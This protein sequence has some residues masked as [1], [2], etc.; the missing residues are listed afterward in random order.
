MRGARGTTGYRKRKA[1]ER[2]ETTLREYLE[3]LSPE[4]L[5]ALLI[6]DLEEQRQ[7]RE[8]GDSKLRPKPAMRTDRLS[9]PG[10]PA[11]PTDRSPT[12]VPQK[13]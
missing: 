8:I 3:S 11:V 7:R 10:R 5:T 9:R 4:K 2:A 13:T 1:N 12:S 6:E